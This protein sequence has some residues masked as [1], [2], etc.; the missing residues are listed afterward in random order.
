[1]NVLQLEIAKKAAE[2]DAKS[3]MWNMYHHFKKNHGMLN[4]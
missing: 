2:A 1:V 4:W 3:N